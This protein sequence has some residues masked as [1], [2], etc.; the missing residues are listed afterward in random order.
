MTRD[1]LLEG[2]YINPSTSSPPLPSPFSY[3]PHTGQLL[4]QA[5]LATANSKP[6]PEPVI[7]NSLFLGLDLS[8]QALKGVFVNELLEVVAEYVVRFDDDLPQYGT[9][10]GVHMDQDGQVTSPTIMFV[11]ALEMLFERVSETAKGQDFLQRT[12]A[13]SGAAQQHAT[14]YWSSTASA[15]LKNL[16]SSQPLHPQMTHAFS[17]SESPNWQDSS[18]T[19]E[20]RDMEDAVG[21]PVAMAR[22]T[23]SRAHERFSG[24]QILEFRRTRPEVY[25]ATSRISLVSS[26]LTTMLCADGEIKPIEESD[27]CGMN[28]WDLEHGQ[29][30]DPDLVQFVAGPGLE[31]VDDL[32]RKL[33]PVEKDGGVSAGK[34]GAYWVDRFGIGKD[35]VVCHVTGD[36]NGTILS[37]SLLTGQVVVSLGTSDTILLSTTDYAPHPDV[38]VFSYP[39]NRSGG[40]RS[41]MA[42]LCYKNGSLPREH[43]RDVYANGSWD[44]FNALVD[45]AGEPDD[46]EAK[47]RPIGFYFLKPEIIPHHGYGVHRF[48]GDGRAVKEFKDPLL[49]A[50]A[51][52]ESQFLSFRMRVGAMLVEDGLP[53]RIFAVGGGSANHTLLSTLST[54]LSAPVFKP[55]SSSSNSCALGGCFKAYW[56]WSRLERERNGLTDSSEWTF[57]VAIRDARAKRGGA[58]KSGREAEATAELVA[59]PDYNATAAYE[60]MMERFRE[61]EKRCCGEVAQN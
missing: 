18:T 1:D 48:E 31:A 22:R 43:V 40:K 49:N 53:Q 7:G 34:I 27:A 39:A 50:R 16:D 32:I 23:G 11:H 14:V 47:T 3:D 6:Q 15:T 55:T 57:E 8:T 58:G 30:W 29:D 41:Y 51:V 4:F 54:V 38:H 42:M 44:E 61:L 20:C 2:V 24:P 10:S 45:K 33:G 5:M 35:C 25:A 17:R 26:F 60:V 12:V 56:C 59:A 19:Q 9:K 37:F 52:L 28:L 46:V 13:V 21:G 36:N